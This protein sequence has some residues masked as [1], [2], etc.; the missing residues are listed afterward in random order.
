MKPWTK[1][2]EKIYNFLIIFY[3]LLFLLFFRRHGIQYFTQFFRIFMNFSHAAFKFLMLIT[4][5]CEQCLSVAFSFLA[6]HAVTTPVTSIRTVHSFPVRIILSILICN[7][8][9]HRAISLQMGFPIEE[10]FSSYSVMTFPT[11]ISSW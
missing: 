11:I 9:S 7:Y 6:A 4:E 10:N 3:F 8:S 5:L 2:Q 1:S